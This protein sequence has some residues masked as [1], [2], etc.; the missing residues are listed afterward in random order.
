[1]SY[2]LTVSG[3]VVRRRR[4]NILDD[5]SFQH[6]GGVLG[7]AGAN[8][9]G[10]TTLLRT[11]AGLLRPDVG[12]VL[13]DQEGRP[14]R[15][16][17][18]ARMLPQAFDYPRNLRLKDFVAYSAWLNGAGKNSENA[19]TE[20]LASVDLADSAR[21][22]LGE[23]SGGMVR[24]AGLAAVLA[25]DPGLVILDEPTTGVDPEQRI[26]MRAL[27]GQIAERKPIL[28][29][30]HIAE[31]LEQL[32]GRLLVLGTGRLLFDGAPQDL[33]R[34]TGTATLE[35]AIVTLPRSAAA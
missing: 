32:C 28:L 4:R 30:S 11:C 35:T 16:S 23:A 19:A 18:R 2:L 5:V 7:L 10:K 29:S 26:V 1:M 20:A 31:D 3:V 22:L 13:L 6:E 21:T 33:I 9:A 17:Q 15:L 14:V 12:T 27:I 8:G 34:A 24:R 25:T